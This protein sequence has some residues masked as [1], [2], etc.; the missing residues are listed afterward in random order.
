[1]Q[2][3]SRRVSRL[4][5]YLI[6]LNSTIMVLEIIVL[7]ERNFQITAGGGGGLHFYLKT[8]QSF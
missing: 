3:Q 4:G 7:G 8:C 5:A 1:M 6:I 2:P